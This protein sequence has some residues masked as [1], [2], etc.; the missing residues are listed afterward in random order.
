MLVV[1]AQMWRTQA[2][3]IPEVIVQIHNDGF[4]SAADNNPL[5]GTLLERLISW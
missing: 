5:E 4:G 3:V 1:N 2:D